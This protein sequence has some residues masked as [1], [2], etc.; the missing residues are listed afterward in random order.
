MLGRLIKPL[1]DCPGQWLRDRLLLLADQ[2]NSSQGGTV[3]LRPALEA[4]GLSFEGPEEAVAHADRG[5]RVSALELGYWQ[6]E[7]EK[8][9]RCAGG[10][11]GTRR[12]V[13]EE[14]LASML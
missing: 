5:Q 7:A 4:A 8:G 2:L 1:A 11:E 6:E 10:M 12:D 3:A 13:P 9:H 14:I